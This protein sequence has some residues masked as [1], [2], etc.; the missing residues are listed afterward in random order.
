VR[1]RLEVLDEHIF[2]S[3][4][5][6]GVVSIEIEQVDNA[7][8]NPNQENRKREVQMGKEVAD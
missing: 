8:Y 7:Q 5:T 6:R 2:A 3:F 4:K 1:F